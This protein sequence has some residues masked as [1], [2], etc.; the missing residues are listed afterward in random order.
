MNKNFIWSPQQ[1][2]LS[3]ID[4]KNLRGGTARFKKKKQSFSFFFFPSL[5]PF[6]LYP[7]HDSNVSSTAG[8]FPVGQG[9]FTM[10]RN[11]AGCTYPREN[12][13]RNA[14]FPF[15]CTASP[16][17]SVICLHGLCSSCNFKGNGLF[18]VRFRGNETV[19]DARCSSPLSRGS[20]SKWC[21]CTEDIPDEI[22]H[23]GWNF[24]RNIFISIIEGGIFDREK[25]VK[26][27]SRRE[28]SIF[29]FS[30][31]PSLLIEKFNVVK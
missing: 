23:V 25:V 31:S 2:K 17:V 4:V 7:P 6:F 22:S 26:N 18:R 8:T 28:I 16:V 15:V 5:P 20:R 13:P 1:Q 10:K 30:V 14:T 3:R 24:E 9:K 11:R 27:C 19:L 21:T 12:T 29:L